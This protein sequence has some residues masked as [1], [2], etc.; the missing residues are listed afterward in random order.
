[1]WRR[2]EGNSSKYWYSQTLGLEGIV[3]EM[4][5]LSARQEKRQE[6]QMERHAGRGTPYMR[7]GV[8]VAR[9]GM[10]MLPRKLVRMLE[11]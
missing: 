7:H 11:R 9:R 5:A 2:H 1:M 10:R 4:T 6:R 3:T 8:R